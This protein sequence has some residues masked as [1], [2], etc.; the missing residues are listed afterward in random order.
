MEPFSTLLALCVGKPLVTGKFPSHRQWREAL[1]VFFDL[2]L[3]NRLSKQSGYQWFETPSRSL[4][5]HCN[6]HLGTDR[7]SSKSWCVTWA[8]IDCLI[9]NGMHP[10]GRYST[11]QLS[12]HKP[13]IFTLSHLWP[14]QWSATVHWEKKI[15]GKSMGLIT[16]LIF[17]CFYR[18]GEV[19]GE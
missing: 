18:W 15:I 4:W 7:T 19:Y 14:N 17:V 3:N 9:V 16:I 12:G 13:H 5:R 1:I 6:V 2:H 10:A 11:A 8:N